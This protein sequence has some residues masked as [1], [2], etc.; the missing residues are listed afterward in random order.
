MSKEVFEKIIYRIKQENIAVSEFILH[1]NGEPLIDAELFQ[2]IKKLKHEFPNSRVRFT[3]NFALANEKIIDE[4][5]ESGLDGI[6]CSLNS[7]NAMTYNEIMGLDYQHTLDNI[8][9]LLCKKEE[10]NSN[11]E[12]GLSIVSNQ[13]NKEETEKFKELYKDKVDIRVMKLGSWVD[14]EQHEH[15]YVHNREGICSI[16]YRTVNILSN[17]DFA[18][19]CFDAEGIVGKNIMDCTIEEAWS[20]R[21]FSEIRQWHLHKGRTNERCINCSF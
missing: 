3:T 18:L 16:L 4:I 17:G 21:V 11:L 10:N 15:I 8:N 6:M 12:I 19:C 2:R 14:K 1:I 5:F 13:D 7:V 9:K 20:S